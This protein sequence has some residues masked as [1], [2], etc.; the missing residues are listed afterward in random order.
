MKGLLDFIKTTI[1]GGVLCLVPIVALL[2]IIGKAHQIV[3]KL[4]TPL[5]AHIPFTSPL[6]LEK[7]K[8]LAIFVPGASSPWSGAVYFMTEDRIK[9]L[10]V[11]LKSAL[12]CVKR[13]GM[14]SKAMMQGRL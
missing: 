6:G 2:A 11:P 14:G 9:P 7:P 8:L 13:L 10:D 12:N 4:V 1:V 5:A 3:S